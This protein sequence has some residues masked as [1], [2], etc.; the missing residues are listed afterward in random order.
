MLFFSLD[1]ET[2]AS[3]LYGPLY[4]SD[5]LMQVVWNCM[6]IRYHAISNLVRRR[7]SP[8]GGI[9]Y[10]AHYGPAGY[11]CKLHATELRL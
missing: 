4:E 9:T 2:P 5:S 10:V 7:E 6:P 1:F 8:N 11:G 3:V